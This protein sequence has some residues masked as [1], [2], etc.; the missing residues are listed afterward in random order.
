MNM[1]VPCHLSF[2]FPSARC[3]D[4]RRHVN[5]VTARVHHWHFLALNIRHRDFARVRRTGLFLHG[6]RI[7]V[8]AHQHSRPV[9]VLHHADNAV[10]FPIWIIV[11]PE[12][13]GNFT[14]G[15]A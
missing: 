5:I 10:T 11:M 7:H 1:I 14:A 8:S 6:Q 13:L 4:Q 3:A 2:S 15:S 12:I 9:A